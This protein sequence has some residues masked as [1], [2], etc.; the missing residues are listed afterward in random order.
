MKTLAIG[1]ATATISFAN[2][3]DIST[4][5]ASWQVA[6][7]GVSGFVA[8]TTL[9]TGETNGDWATAPT[10]SSWISWGSVQGTSCVVGQ[11]PGNGCANTVFNTTNGDVWEYLLT[12]SS[13]DLGGATAGS[14]NF[15]FGADD[16]VNL[17]VG[18][19]P[20]QDWS[21][22]GP[23]GCSG[24]PPTSAGGSQA[25]YN[26]CV[27]TVNFNASD[28]TGAG[29]LTLQGYVT[30]APINFCPACGDP[31]GFVLEGDITTAG[32][33]SPVPEPAALPLIGVAGF[34]MLWIRRRR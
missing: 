18:N 34:A 3:V 32:S 6:G 13:A 21:S 30:N 11:T 10:G 16:S 27:G 22:P 24:T 7:P 12:I 33:T 14:V 26:N 23:L 31:T 25:T 29:A 28:L 1:L 20:G 9:N 17:F 2:V 4:G 5:T 15:I 8:A 19:E